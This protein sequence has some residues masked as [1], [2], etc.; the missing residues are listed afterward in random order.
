MLALGPKFSQPAI[1]DRRAGS[2]WKAIY[3]IVVLGYSLEVLPLS[4]EAGRE[5]ENQEMMALSLGL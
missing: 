3:N 4:H 1:G 5:L 2:S